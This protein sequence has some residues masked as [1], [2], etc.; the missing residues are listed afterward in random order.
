MA[1]SEKDHT[2]M[3]MKH[4]NDEQPPSRKP[5]SDKGKRQLTPRDLDTLL[6]IG[7]QYTY[8]FDQLQTILA[9]HPDT[10]SAE[11]EFLSETR[12]RAAIEKWKQLGLADSRKILHD[13]P[14]WVWLTRRGLYHVHLNV[15]YWEPE[16]SDLEHYFSV[17]ETRAHLEGIYKSNPEYQDVEW[18]SERLWRA[19]R[20]Q[21]L[22]EKKRDN[23]LWIPEEYQS[24]HRPDA[25]LRYRQGEDDYV[26]AL[27]I[28][29][30]WKSYPTLKAIWNELLAHYGSVWYY[31]DEDIKHSFETF[32]TRYQ[33]EK[34]AYGE[35]ASDRRQ[36]IHVY[37]LRQVL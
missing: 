30:S 5:R 23:A 11:R 1:T 31:V 35:P 9:R 27:E 3:A 22:K 19:R 16:H 33:N 14:Q 13:A 6:L 26:I 20:D 8:C 24:K 28:E 25:L 32:L 36:R 34:P 17:N 2:T 21:W 15:A 10:T 37:D 12:T 7:Q 18:E 29:L 4:P